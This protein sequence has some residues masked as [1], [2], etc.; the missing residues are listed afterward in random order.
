MSRKAKRP[1]G[2]IAAV[3]ALAIGA[4]AC[5]GTPDTVA[6]NPAAETGATSP[7]SSTSEAPVVTDKGAASRVVDLAGAAALAQ[8]M[9]NEWVAYVGSVVATGRPDSD[10]AEKL[11]ALYDSDLVTFDAAA[12]GAC[13]IREV[14]SLN[15]A[16]GQALWEHSSWRD[17]GAEIA[18]ADGSRQDLWTLTVLDNL[19][20]GAYDGSAY[21]DVVVGPGGVVGHL[22]LT[23]DPEGGSTG[24][25]HLSLVG[26]LGGALTVA[27]KAQ[28][29]LDA[30]AQPAG[31]A[32]MVDGNF[33]ARAF[34][35][36]VGGDSGA[37]FA[38]RPGFPADPADPEPIVSTGSNKWDLITTDDPSAYVCASYLGQGPEEFLPAS[39][40][41][42]YETL[43]D[44]YL[45]RAKFSDGTAIDMRV[46]SEIGSKADADAELDR[47]LVPLGQLPTVLRRDI[48]RFAVR[49]GDNTATA[50]QGEGMMLQSGNAAVRLG[51]NRLEETLFHESVHTSLDPT[52]S[53]QR[54]QGWMDAQ[55]ADSRWLTK[56]GREN[57]DNEDLAETALYAL[58]VLRHPDRFPAGVADEI[59]NRIPNRLKFIAQVFPAGEPLITETDTTVTCD[60]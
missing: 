39:K 29:F 47:Y 46:H 27:P 16:V 22:G 40:D 12:L 36:S 14:D 10:L 44:A 9:S 48:G 49:L 37:V 33:E 35:S 13:V 50:S 3:I 53:Y 59:A 21:S 58:A 43:Q 15:Q 51:D 4:T 57:P 28:V 45:Y 17:H 31:L 24:D 38:R 11:A 20:A 26:C 60:G 34:F 41:G 25:E 23:P 1:R 8:E 6:S 55:G 18:A 32:S 30:A 56:Y 7:P 54:S 52:Y 2:R 42:G 19:V 5:T